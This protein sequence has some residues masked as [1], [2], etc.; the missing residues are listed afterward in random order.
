STTTVN[1]PGTY[2]VSVQQV[3]NPG[4]RLCPASLSIPITSS[5]GIGIMSGNAT[6]CNDG[7]AT[8]PVN[9][10]LT[11]T[12]PWSITYAIDG[13]NQTPI[14]G[15]MSSPYTISGTAPH[16]YSL[17]AVKDNTPCNGNASGS[18]VIKGYPE[19]PVGHDNTF[20]APASTTLSVDNDGG[21]YQWY[22]SGGTLLYTGT[23]FTTP[24]LASTTVYYVKNSSITT[25][26]NKSVAFLNNTQYGTGGNN[27][28]TNLT[29]HQDLWLKFTA[30]SSFTFNSVN[31]DVTITATP[32]LAG[33][34]VVVY[35]DDLT[36]AALSTSYVKSVSGFALG[37]QSILVPFGGYSII[38]GHQYQISYD[39]MT[40]SLKGNMY[41]DF[42]GARGGWTTAP[43]VITKDPEVTIT[44][45][46]QG[47]YPG[48]FNWQ[49]T[50]GDPASSCGKTPVTAYATLP[51]SLLYFRAY[52]KE[53]GTAL[54]QW[55]TASEEN[56]DYFTLQRSA[57][58]VQFTDIVRIKGA[59]N[60]SNV[61]TYTY[62]DD[63][64]LSGISYYRIKQTDFDGKYT[65]SNIAKI[66][67]SAWSTFTMNLSPNPSTSGNSVFLDLFGV[68]TNSKVPVA[69]Y[70]MLGR[71]IYSSVLISTESGTIHEDL[72][73][74]TYL[75][76]G[77]YIV[78]VAPS[79][80]N[81]YKQK[82]MI[83]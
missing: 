54:L 52:L 3:Q 15:I 69:I 12:P 4:A 34:Q 45:P 39:A 36:N 64:A 37:T 71:L 47:W 40:G 22:N 53:H 59:G 75:S 18:A 68:T 5:G 55:S 42:V 24:V 61:N 63:H 43:A 83:Y 35:I 77:T 80:M 8:T 78:S 57:D 19:L 38:A 13:V 23:T 21:T 82:L 67:D 17:V 32:Q 56:N 51:V 2:T 26:V 72:G 79:G 46:N 27:T 76:H 60:S 11:G 65:Y 25:V 58:G 14:T 29:V 28:P 66:D 73:D 48:I 20:A 6:I 9:V 10:A 7:T 81:E 44:V 16:T 31:V 62:T 30:N 1:T 33:T 50:E 70:D 41:Y 49:I 74:L